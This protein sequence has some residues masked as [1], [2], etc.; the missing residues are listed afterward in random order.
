MPMIIK[1]FLSYKD[2]IMKLIKNIKK[3]VNNNPQIISKGKWVALK[4]ILGVDDKDF[5]FK[6]LHSF[7]DLKIKFNDLFFFFNTEEKMPSPPVTKIF[8]FIC[9]IYQ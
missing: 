1:I 9:C 3:S 4:F 2:N 8:F 6:I 7:F 5:I